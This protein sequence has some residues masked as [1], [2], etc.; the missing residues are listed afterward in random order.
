VARRES[1]KPV[2]ESDFLRFAHPR[3][4][5]GSH[6]RLPGREHGCLYGST[7]NRR[8]LQ[9]SS[10]ARRVSR[11]GC[12]DPP[13]RPL[14]K[15]R[16][17]TDPDTQVKGTRPL[18]CRLCLATALTGA[19]ALALLTVTF[20]CDRPLSTVTMPSKSNRDEEDKE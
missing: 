1:R 16:K 10:R 20:K 2:R 9:W 4:R 13:R 8:S 14:A 5:G 7:E 19:T 3:A 12:L 11:A 18:L 6:S 15:A 17:P